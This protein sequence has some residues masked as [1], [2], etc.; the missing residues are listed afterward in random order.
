MKR[1]L[2]G[3]YLSVFGLG[4]FPKIPGTLMSAL[5]AVDLYFLRQF[6]FDMS[7][8]WKLSFLL[9]TWLYLLILAWWCIQEMF[10]KDYDRTWV[11][12]DEVLGMMIAC[13]LAFFLQGDLI[14]FFVL[15]FCLYRF[16]NVVKP[17]GIADIDF[18]DSPI[19]TLMGDI[20]AGVYTFLCILILHILS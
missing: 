6:I 11:V 7:T 14:F 3:T 15:S 9:L 4:F 13:S 5:V 8:W 18:L 1:F 19:S 17:F 20:V 10:R 2:I 12:I 16:F